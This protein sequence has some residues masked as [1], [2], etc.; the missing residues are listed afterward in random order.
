V[1]YF[2]H[3]RYGTFL[4]SS[5]D[6]SEPSLKLP[7]GDSLMCLSGEP[8]WNLPPFFSFLGFPSPALVEVMALFF[9][10]DEELLVERRGSFL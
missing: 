6:V 8:I 7:L 1:N 4:T 2:S 10:S 9:S 3:I 5:P